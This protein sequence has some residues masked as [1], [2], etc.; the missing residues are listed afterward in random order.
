MQERPPPLI[1]LAGAL[2]ALLLLGA[3]A[4]PVQAAVTTFADGTFA[5]GTWTLIEVESNQGG[6]VATEV[7]ADGDPGEALRIAVTINPAT[8]YSAI[9]GVFF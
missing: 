5:A 8:E 1:S 2:S 4:A 6:S 3:G 9:A 7:V